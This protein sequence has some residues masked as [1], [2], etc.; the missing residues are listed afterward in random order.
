MSDTPYKPLTIG[1][2]LLTFVIM[3][4]PLVNIVMLI[5][6][7]ANGSTHASKKSFAQAYLIFLCAIF[8]VAIVAALI[9]PLF[10][11]MAR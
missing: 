3:A 10:A 2:W 1:N 7:A 4:I 5:V 8:V 11:H 9:L 6:W